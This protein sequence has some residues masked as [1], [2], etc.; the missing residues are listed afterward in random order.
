MSALVENMFSARVTPWH[1]LGTVVS[2]AL[3]SEE[4]IEKAGLAWDVYPEE[5]YTKNGVKI[6]GAY[7]NVRSSDGSALGI[8]GE[9]YQIVQNSEAFTFTDA[10]L[11]EGVKY[12]TAGSLKGGRVIWLL[13]KMP[14]TYRIL[15]DNIEEYCC[16]TNSFD[17]SGAIKVALTGVRVVCSNTLA[18]ALKS[19]KR[20]W[21]ARHTGS[22]DTKMEQ[23]RQTLE[24]AETYMDSLNNTFEDLYKIKLNRDKVV[25]LVSDLVPV[26][27][28]ATNRVKQNVENIRM[29]ILF[30]YDEAPDL[31]DREET[32]ARFI[33]AVADSTS[34]RQPARLTSNYQANFFYSQINGNTM[35]DKAMS[36]VMAA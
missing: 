7:A 3:S 4:A 10:L 14:K 20:T 36:M 19:A 29:D 26:E 18:A 16:F 5:V 8:V 22:I 32:G 27:D 6:P 11:G 9:R 33:Q 31:K 23:A 21:S 15:G 1:G 30:R 13:A 24:L 35:L 34:H 2:E 28:D 17:G 12:E 25:K